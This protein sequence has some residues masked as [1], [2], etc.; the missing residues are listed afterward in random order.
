MKVQ[1]D[2][3]GVL[4]LLLSSNGGK[5]ILEEG[6]CPEEEYCDD[7]L[8]MDESEGELCRVDLLVLVLVFVVRGE[9][10]S[11]LIIK[12]APDVGEGVV[13]RGGGR[14]RR[15]GRGGDREAAIGG[16]GR[17]GDTVGELRCLGEECICSEGIC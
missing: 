1:G 7:V 4:L 6:G 10:E 15:G 12:A 13:R 9:G 3:D 17:G 14:D 16:S 8:A 11:E 2:C 5:N